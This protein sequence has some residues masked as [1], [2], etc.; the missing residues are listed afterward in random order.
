M[1]PEAIR[2]FTELLKHYR[3]G[4]RLRIANAQVIS[5]DV[6]YRF[7]DHWSA[8]SGCRS[9]VNAVYNHL[10]ELLFVIQVTL[11]GKALGLGERIDKGHRDGL[12]TAFQHCL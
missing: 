10:H 1:P 6:Q 2:H 9:F 7:A 11:A 4:V 3:L 5:F 12:N 8:P